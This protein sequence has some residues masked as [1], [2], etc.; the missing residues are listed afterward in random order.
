M[1]LDASF[2][3]VRKFLTPHDRVTRLLTTTRKIRRSRADFTCEWFDRHL[4][5]FLRGGKE[6]I[7]VSGK[8]RTGK[9]F[10]ADWTVERLQSL[11]G[12]RASEVVSY[13]IGKYLIP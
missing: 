11:S 6:I 9:S 10:L 1:K 2:E 3:L 8:P 12:R 5:E 13:T 7:I 4:A